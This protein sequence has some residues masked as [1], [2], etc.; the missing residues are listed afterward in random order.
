MSNRNN[1]R[2]KIISNMNWIFFCILFQKKFLESCPKGPSSDV[3][4][5]VGEGQNDLKSFKEM[6]KNILVVR[7]PQ[8]EGL[9]KVINF[10]KKTLTGLNAGKRIFSIFDSAKL[11]EFY[12]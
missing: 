6:L 11:K 3:I 5:C 7:P 10:I 12:F 2:Q 8:S 1:A 4:K 9:K